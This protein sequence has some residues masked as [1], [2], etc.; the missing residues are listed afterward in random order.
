ME[1][2]SFERLLETTNAVVAT[3]QGSHNLKHTHLYCIFYFKLDHN[4]RN[5]HRIVV[6]KT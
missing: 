4:L 3:G 1:A 6:D 5:A 2:D